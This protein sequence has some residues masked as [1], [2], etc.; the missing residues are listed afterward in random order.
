MD[1]THQQALQ[2]AERLSQLSDEALFHE[3]GLRVEDVKRPGGEE[4]QQYYSG[5]FLAPDATMGA[6]VLGEIGRRWWGNLEP[7]LMHLVCDPNNK[8]MKEL[9]GNRSI[10][11]LA[12]GLAVSG[13][14][15]LAAPSVVIV[16]SS[17]LAL[18]ISEA[19]LKAVCDTW[20]EHSR[21]LTPQAPGDVLGRGSSEQDKG[22]CSD[23]PAISS[24]LAP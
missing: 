9:T 6:G 14:A 21:T 11:A 16:V 1:E 23:D 18:K 13:L 12:A 24:P 17:I 22:N 3:L 4:R 20:A 8:E 2:E 15:V 5:E 19:G 10:P 7:Q